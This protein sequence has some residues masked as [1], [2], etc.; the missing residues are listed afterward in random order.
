M[1]R[2]F[3]CFF[4]LAASAHVRTSSAVKHLPR[5]R[6]KLTDDEAG[7]AAEEFFDYPLQWRHFG[8]LEPGE[9]AAAFSVPTL[10]GE[11]AYRPGEEGSAG[12]S[13]LVH[14][15]TNKSAFLECLWSSSASLAS[16]VLELPNS[17]YVLF[18]SLD[19]SAATDALWMQ[20]RLH[21]AAKQHGKEEVLS[22]LHVSPVP[23]FAVANWIASVLYSWTC[24]GHNCGL[25]QAVFTSVGWDM[26][27]IV[28]RLDARYDWLTGRWAKTKYELRDVGDGCRPAPSLE[29]AVAWVSDGNCS[30]FAKVANMAK[31]NASGV[32]VYA[33]PG[34]AIQDMNCAGDEC[35]VPLELPAAML[36][37]QSKVDLALSSGMSV[38]VSF[39][40]TPTPNFFLGID[41][42]GML[43]EMGWFLYPS[44]SFLNWQAQWF[45]FWSAM[46]LRL[47][48]PATVV[49]VFDKAEMQGD[50]GAVADVN[51]PP[52]LWR[53]D[54]LT[55]DASL[56][57]PGGRDATCPP[58]DHVVQL[59][60]CCDPLG[61]Y[62][63][64][65]M[66]RWVTAFRRG[67]GHWQTD[68]SP[69]LPV[70]DASV[71]RL[72]M[73]T[74]PWARP[75]SVSLN[76]R[77]SVANVTEEKL[78]PFRVMSLYDGGTFDK[79]Y[80]LRHPP[81]KFPVP[82]ST[83][84][85]ELYAVITGHGSDDN[86]CGEF[87]VTSHHFLINDVHN[88][89]LAFSTAG[90]ALGCAA[91]VKEGAVPNEHGT[92]LY[93]R[94]GW[95]DGLQVDP[96]R[97]DVTAQLDVS[98]QA[99]NTVVYRGLFN[100]EDPNPTQQPGYIIVTSFLIFYK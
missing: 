97:T 24:A 75:W 89:T 94:G 26:P 30:F 83:K 8:G 17:A 98:G 67:I 95:C 50:K 57:C 53:F 54:T 18:L 66:G 42:Q 79:T 15:F 84:K 27:V 1:W 58:W 52:D 11:F 80:N 6:L 85:V 35:D 100:G 81:I 87:C 37:I 16:L 92:W 19:D 62:C 76:L 43:A 12:V 73:K 34:S 46:Q 20:E 36:H 60:V 21:A 44:F 88:N 33:R 68:V 72:T 86:G 3:Y 77:F 64:L 59:F 74:V 5:R 47:Q 78:R 23:V 93:G 45:D 90:T 2:L 29:G 71:C 48:S 13:V 10:S 41:Q 56:S 9:P 49:A 22:R 61:P 63:H 82:A 91:R 31:S 4:L 7:R 96:W 38:K 65:E 40:T 39:Q 69:L 99:S 14:A 51:M 55:L 32:L 70:L 28:K 25:A